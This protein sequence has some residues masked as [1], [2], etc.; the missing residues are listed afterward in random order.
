[1]PRAAK[2]STS[3]AQII[4]LSGY[5]QSEVAREANI[6]LRTLSDYCRGYTV[7]KRGQLEAIAR[8]LGCPVEAL[9][10]DDVTC[11]IV[12]SSNRV[13]LTED[14]NDMKKDGLSRRETINLLAGVPFL[15]LAPISCLLRN[16]EILAI[17]ATN[18]PI[19]W[20]LHF[21]GHHTEIRSILP[22][23]LSLLSA[24]AQQP[25][26]YQQ[27]AARLASQVHQL[28][29]L[30]A[31]HYQDFNAALW[32]TNQ[33]FLYAELAEDASLQIASLIREAHIHFSFNQPELMLKVYQK[34]M[35]YCT[36]VPALF[37]GRVYIGLAVAHSYFRREKQ[38][39][40]RYLGLARDTFPEYPEKDPDYAYTYWDGF[41]TANFEGLT[42]LNLN[43]PRD[44]Y[45]I[46]DKIGKSTLR[47]THRVEWLVRQ[48]A[49]F[50]KLGDLDQTC[51]SLEQSATTA[52][53][54]GSH[55]RLHETQTIYQQARTKWPQE[56]QI[57]ELE[58]QFPELVL[59]KQ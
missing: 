41:T 37:Q 11:G 21:D 55:L 6:A 13:S 8:V 18:I 1:M 15:S 56:N 3:L 47:C 33:S 26:H 57:K 4:K 16:E 22:D 35:Q 30:L 59:A 54:L 27:Q 38:N 2:Y 23:Y 46:F 7:A 43:Q 48:S 39:A 5:T 45:K 51:C 20:R 31:I 17:S 24:L 58:E 50:F 49:T 36:R 14:S 19:L 12:A 53:A 10:P 9:L 28:A 44:A 34:A 29:Y 52:V 25:S 42:Y 32:H 40:L